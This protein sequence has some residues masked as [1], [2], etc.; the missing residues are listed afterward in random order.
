MMPS[1]LLDVDGV[2]ADF[3]EA[4][5][6][7]LGGT[8]SLSDVTTWDFSSIVGFD[9]QAAGR[10]WRAYGFCAGI[11]LTPGAYEGVRALM[12]IADVTFCTSPM[13]G[14]RYWMYE[15]AAWLARHFPPA[16]VIF[17]HDKSKVHGDYLIDDRPKHLRAWRW[18]KAICWDAPDNRIYWWGQRVHDWDELVSYI[19]RG[20]K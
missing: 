13:A 1:V 12:Q 9:P 14:S 5:R 19:E 18:G 10:V 7:A 17:A 4:T 20:I 3:V 8:W 15:R 6:E 16:E 11:P 2:C